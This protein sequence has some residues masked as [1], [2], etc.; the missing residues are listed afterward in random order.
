MPGSSSG[1]A[2]MV[3]VGVGST[4]CVTGFGLAGMVGSSAAGGG[5]SG[6]EDRESFTP[7]RCSS[8]KD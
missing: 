5:G 1:S 7:V 4:S 2:E 8:I 3:T 6:G